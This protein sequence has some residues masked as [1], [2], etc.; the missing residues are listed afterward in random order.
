MSLPAFAAL[1]ERLV[2]TPGRLAKLALLRDWYATQPDPDRGVG[3][4]ALTG[5][6]VFTAAKPALIRD[7]VAA[8]TDPVLLALSHDYVGDFAETVALIWPEREGV[9]TPA[10]DLAEVV[11]ALELT[12][13][14]ELPGLIAGWLDALDA[15]GRLALI[16]LITGGLRVGVSGRLAR[17]ALAEWSG[18]AVEEIEEVW[19][20]VAPPYTALFHWLEGKAERPDP[21]EAPVFRPLMLAHPLEDADL[22][23]L[24]PA[25]WRAEWKWDGIR[26]QLTAGPGGR[27]LW[28]R[29]GED[30]S[31]AFPEIIEAM[32]FH[33]VLDG[34]L[35]VVREGEVAPFAD[36]QQRLNR[37]VVTPKMQKDYPAGVRLYDLLFEGTEDLRGLPFDQ[38][39]ARLEAWVA[40]HAP[41]RMDLSPQ[42]A[43]A[44]VAQLA[45][46]R[47]GA[48][49]A[50][51]EGLM[52]KRA[53][54]PYVAGRVKGLWWKWKRAPLSIDAVLMYAQRGHGKRSSFYSD[55]TFGL[56]RPDGQGG[57]ELV[58][59]GKAYSGYTDQE[60]TW[61]DRW[62][63]NHTTGRFGPVREVEKALVLEVIFDAAQLSTRHKSGVA[64]R[65]PRIARIRTDKPASEADRLENLMSYVAAARPEEG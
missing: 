4:A 37:K 53:D 59:V 49:A 27:R 18:R 60:L 61:L 24:D 52:L 46:I 47:E 12:P 40:R 65:F 7:M 41:A 44:S 14:A 64:L 11:E 8:R 9:N 20:G 45:E 63:R 31:G 25:Q 39:R 32:N 33:A 23:A 29:G 36:L 58:P 35:L 38:R 56:W 34:E 15:T 42:I 13:K 43:F 16:K 62:I 30:V 50:S 22:A 5:E 48:R 26:V 6:L 51:I 21:R 54:S 19:H 17:V 55:Y 1:L 28:S 2:F 3:L 10:P 57:E